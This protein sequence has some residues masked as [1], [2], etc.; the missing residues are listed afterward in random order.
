MDIYWG[1]IDPTDEGGQFHDRGSQY[2]TGIF[3]INDEQHK[4]AETSKKSME[5]KLKKPLYTEITAASEF[6]PAEE[7]HQHYYKKNPIRYNA[8]KYGSGRISR[9]KEIWEK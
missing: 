7:Y 5:N 6:Y 4:L 1:N 2:R 9:L 8:Y 3:Y